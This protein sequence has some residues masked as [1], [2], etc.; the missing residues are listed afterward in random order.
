MAMAN[1]FLYD[2]FLNLF[3]NA[4]RYNRN[5]MARIRVVVS[6]AISSGRRM[7]KVS[8]EDNG[9]GIPDDHKMKVFD[10]FHRIMEKGEVMGSGLG[11]AIVREIIQG[12]DGDIW[13][14]DRIPGDH[15]GGSRFIFMIPE[16]VEEV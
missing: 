14:E 6:K 8:I 16:A 13:V 3:I 5:P 12:L 10:R 4:V 1:E 2:V 15:S 7:I 9:I 11:L